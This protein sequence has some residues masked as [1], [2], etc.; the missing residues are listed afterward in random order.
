MTLSASP[1]TSTGGFVP[2]IDVRHGRRALSTTKFHS[3][4]DAAISKL[5][6]MHDQLEAEDVAALLAGEL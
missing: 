1:S 6:Q 4:C 3:D 5:E 2:D